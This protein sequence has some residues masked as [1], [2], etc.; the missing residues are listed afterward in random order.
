[1]F[2]YA[3][4]QDKNVLSWRSDSVGSGQHMESAV[5]I[6]RIWDLGKSHR[7]GRVWHGHK[8]QDPSQSEDG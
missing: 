8:P 1:V 2:V 3:G 4:N 5:D 6:G 7:L